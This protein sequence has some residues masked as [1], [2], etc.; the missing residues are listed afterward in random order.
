MIKDCQSR[1]FKICGKLHH[2]F[3]HRSKDSPKEHI[4]GSSCLSTQQENV[5]A[6][7][8]TFKESSLTCVL[9]AAAQIKVRDCKG[10]FHTCRAILDFSSQSNFITESSV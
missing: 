10:R 6:T 3:I 2:T 7:Y 5:Q 9:L 4:S 1:G 8:H